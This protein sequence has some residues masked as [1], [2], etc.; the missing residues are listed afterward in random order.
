MARSYDVGYRGQL[1]S[2]G[3]IK[4]ALNQGTYV[5]FEQLIIDDGVERDIISA[6]PARMWLILQNYGTNTIAIGFGNTGGILVGSFIYLNQYDCLIIDKNLPWTG[7]ISAYSTAGAAGYLNKQECSLA[8][9]TA[10]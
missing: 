5:D 7:S 6:N 9:G 10:G 8:R 3:G 1:V 2:L 4:G